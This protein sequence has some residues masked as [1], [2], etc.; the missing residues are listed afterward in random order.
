MIGTLHE[1]GRMHEDIMRFANECIYDGFL[2]P[3]DAKN[4]RVAL[5][6]II[7]NESAALFKERLLFVHTQASL[8]ETYLK[9]N[10]QEANVTI[11]LIAMWQKKMVEENL[12]WSI[13]VITPFR[14]QISAIIHLGYL[15]QVDLS[16]VTIDT[17]ERYQG[18]ARDIIIMS[19][20]VN[21][22]RALSKITSV[23]SDGIDRKLNVAVT[24]ARQQFVLIGNQ[25]V[26]ETEP[27]YRTLISMS[28]MY[29]L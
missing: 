25:S 23:N 28:K 14:A 19:S 16:K 26:L 6:D 10:Q 21:S 17:V 7:L 11:E 8:T 13:G 2:K 9:T 15:R 29:V 20:A 3:V 1:Q 4:Q 27:A 24:R 22:Q 12:Q 18:G 5:T